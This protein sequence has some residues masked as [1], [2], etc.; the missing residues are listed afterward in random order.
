MPAELVDSCRQ[1]INN[2]T[3]ALAEQELNIQFVN[4]GLSNVSFPTG[5]TANMYN[6]ILLWSG[7]DRPNNHSP[8]TFNEA[9]P[10]KMDKEKNHHLT[11]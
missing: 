10:I 6:G 7:S 8:F 5:Y 9:K 2:Q 3:V 1:V 11:L 4:R